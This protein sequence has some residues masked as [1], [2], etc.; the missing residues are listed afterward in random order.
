MK[1]L[2]M[3]TTFNTTIC[4]S[5]GWRVMKWTVSFQM[6]LNQRKNQRQELNN[7]KI[8]FKINTK[9]TSRLMKI[10]KNGLCHDLLQGDSK[11]SSTLNNS[12]L[13]GLMSL[14]RSWKIHLQVTQK[15]MMLSLKIQPLAQILLKIFRLLMLLVKMVPQLVL[16]QHLKLPIKVL[17]QLMRNKMVM[18]KS[19]HEIISE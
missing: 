7:S 9:K 16:I 6:M 4:S 10:L 3:L 2:R 8:I 5:T 12:A 1:Q 19:I 13:F 17:V 11:R 18:S 14:Q 15:I